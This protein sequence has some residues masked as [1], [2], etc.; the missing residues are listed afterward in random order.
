MS[1]KV[2]FKKYL[3]GWP[4]FGGDKKTKKVEFP[5]AFAFG[6]LEAWSAA[7]KDAKV[8]VVSRD[9]DWKQMCAGHASLIWV[10]RLEELLQHFTDTETRFAI[11]KGL[12]E[13]REEL[14]EMLCA[15]PR[16]WTSTSAETCSSKARSM[17]T[18]SSAWTS[19]TSTSWR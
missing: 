16:A 4:P 14:V 9:G 13:R 8:Y 19:W 18:R 7:N 11:K 17:A 1:A 3:K 5:D 10:A 6:A 15:G 2:I 12:E